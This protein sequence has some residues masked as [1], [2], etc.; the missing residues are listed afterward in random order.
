MMKCYLY[1]LVLVA[2]TTSIPELVT[3]IS[4]V[5]SGALTLADFCVVTSWNARANRV[6]SYGEQLPSSE[7]LTH[8]AIYELDERICAV[9]HV[10]DLDLWQY[11]KGRVP[12]TDPD[13]AYGT[14]GMAREFARIWR[15]TDFA[16]A[17]IAAM[18]GH[19]SGIVSIGGN[20][21]QAA[22]RVLALHDRFYRNEEVAR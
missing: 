12:T 17:G 22:S 18:A 13:A 5:R 8:A 14:P 15:E 2:V 21:E 10:H 16:D 6:H 20:L 7:S 1:S 3:S 19:D 4:A 11:L 9:V